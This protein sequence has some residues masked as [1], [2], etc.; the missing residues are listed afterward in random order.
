MARTRTLLATLAVVVAALSASDAEAQRGRHHIDGIRPEVH[1]D[2]GLHGYFGVG[3]DLEIPLVSDGFLDGVDDEFAIVPGL[4]FLFFD[5][6]YDGDGY[7]GFG[8]AP[9]LTFQWSFYV[10][11]KWSVFPELGFV[12]LFTTDDRNPYY[13]GYGPDRRVWVDP[14]AAFGARWHFSDR[15]ALTFRIGYPFG[16][17]IGITF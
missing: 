16:F 9:N 7:G 13:R 11:D 1:F 15:N 14:V 12:V 6:R 5:Y 8:F 2:L 10:S 17:Q 4:D 3:F